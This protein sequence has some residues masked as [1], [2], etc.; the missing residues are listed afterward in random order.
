MDITPEDTHSS[1]SRLRSRLFRQSYIS[2]NRD[3]KEEEPQDSGSNYIYESVI[4][5]FAKENNLSKAAIMSCFNWHEWDSRFFDQATLNKADFREI[6]SKSCNIPAGLSASLWR[7]CTDVVYV[8]DIKQEQNDND[9]SD[10]NEEWIKL[11]VANVATDD[12]SKSYLTTFRKPSAIHTQPKLINLRRIISVED[13]KEHLVYNLWHK[14]EETKGVYYIKYINDNNE[15]S[16]IFFYYKGHSADIN[17]KKHKKKG[18]SGWIG[19]FKYEGMWGTKRVDLHV[20]VDVRSKKTA[21]NIELYPNQYSPTGKD[22]WESDPLKD[23][24]KDNAYKMNK[25]VCSAW[26]TDNMKNQL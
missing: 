11:N 17:E 24:G 15:E 13:I 21:V 10:Y 6:L 1:R 2:H 22:Y 8:P 3:E 12:L 26:I 19:W 18:D 25:C 23:I 9:Y 4:T 14:D 7:K 20:H 16:K 5:T